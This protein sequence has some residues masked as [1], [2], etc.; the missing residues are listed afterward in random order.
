MAANDYQV[1]GEHYQRSNMQHWDFVAANGLDYFQGCIT[2]YVTRWREK[3]G[4]EDLK[5][6]K[7]YL[8]KYIELIESGST[9]GILTSRGNLVVELDGKQVVVVGEVPKEGDAPLWHW[10]DQQNPDVALCGASYANMHTTDD[11]SQVTC[12]DC[13]LR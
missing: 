7:H 1:G 9:F 3:G 4:V 13:I 12:P 2:K 8:E 11:M 5:K 10:A 6:A